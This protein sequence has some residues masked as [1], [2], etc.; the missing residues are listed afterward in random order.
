MLVGKQGLFLKQQRKIYQCY[1]RPVLLYCCETWELTA[2][3]EA[4]LHGVEHRMIKM[5]CVVRPVDRV[6][7]DVLRDKVGVIVKIE[8]MIIQSRLW[9][10]GYDMCGDITHKYMRLWNLKLLEK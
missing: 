5:I 7:T 6:L 4:R 10:Y 1:V 9:W 2:A 8:D 3:D